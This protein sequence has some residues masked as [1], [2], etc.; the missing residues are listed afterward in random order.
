M[1]SLYILELKG[2][3]KHYQQVYFLFVDNDIQNTRCLFIVYSANK[4]LTEA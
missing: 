4:L 1:Y 2:N 3:L